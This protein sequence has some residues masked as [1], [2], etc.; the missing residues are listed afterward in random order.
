MSYQRDISENQISAEKDPERSIF[1]TK[2]G[3]LPTKGSINTTIILPWWVPCDGAEHLKPRIVSQIGQDASLRD[4][5]G[6]RHVP[7]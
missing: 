6:E 2:Q 1:T 5:I 4:S 3:E 7:A